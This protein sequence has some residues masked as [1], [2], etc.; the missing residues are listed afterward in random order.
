MRMNK[1]VRASLSFE[2]KK[3]IRAAIVLR[4]SKQTRAQ[5][6]AAIKNGADPNKFT[7]HSNYHVRKLAEKY[8][9]RANAKASEA[10]KELSA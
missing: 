10:I 8:I 5:C 1:K 6:E 2:A 4:R 7:S 9:A 3:I